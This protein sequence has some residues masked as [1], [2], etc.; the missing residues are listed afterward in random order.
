MKK[1]ILIIALSLLG[2]LLFLGS[3][4]ALLSWVLRDFGDGLLEFNGVVYE[5]TNAPA[6][7]VSKL[8]IETNPESETAIAD[9]TG[10]LS[11]DI[12]K[13]A[14]EDA[15]VRVGERKGME[16]QGVEAYHHAAISDMNGNFDYFHVVSPRKRKMLIWVAKPGYIEV[17][18]VVPYET[19]SSDIYKIVALLVRNNN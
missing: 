6:D 17:T 14:L 7:A 9:I 4:S 15:V 18:G 11:K 10:K 19:G 13:T 8:Y 5:W 2:I 3:C 1:K 16:T 12:E